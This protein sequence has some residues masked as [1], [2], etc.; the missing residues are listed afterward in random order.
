MPSC[1]LLSVIFNEFETFVFEELINNLFGIAVV[2]Q[3]S[4][5]VVFFGTT[6][7]FDFC[8]ATLTFTVINKFNHRKMIK[9]LF[10]IILLLE[11]LN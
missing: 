7:L 9:K 1:V 3:V 8:C 4:F 11:A 2:Q 6:F 5:V 10:F